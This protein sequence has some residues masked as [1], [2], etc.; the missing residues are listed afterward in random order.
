MIKITKWSPDTCKCVLHFQWDTEEV[1]TEEHDR[2]LTPVW[3]TDSPNPKDNS[4]LCPIHAGLGHSG[5]PT[6]MPIVLEENQRKNKVLGIL[7]RDVKSNFS[8]EDYGWEF[9]ADRKLTVNLKGLSLNQ[10]QLN[11]LKSTIDSELGA[12]KVTVNLV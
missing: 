5:N 2:T 4:Y 7:Q 11:A 8:N 1:V 10:Q 12:D 9:D 6:L 3:V